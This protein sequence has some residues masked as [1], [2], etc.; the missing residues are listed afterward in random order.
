VI[1]LELVAVL[2]IGCGA[3]GFARTVHPP[4]VRLA[5]RVRPYN[6]VGRAGLGLAPDVAVRP[7]R[8]G[9]VESFVRPLFGGWVRGIGRRIESRSD[10]ELVK[11]LHQAGR[12]DLTVEEFRAR[13]VLRGAGGAAAF[14]GLGVVGLRSPVLAVA[15]AIAGF[16]WGSS[17][18][19]AGVDRAVVDRKARVRLELSTVSQLLALHVRTGAGLMHAVQRFSERG[20]GV[21]AEELRAVVASV[22]AGSRESD[23][24]RR[25]AELTSAPE[26]ARMHLLFANGVERGADLAASLLVIA[27]DLREAR[28]DD[29]KR[30]AVK[31]RAAM[32]LPTIGILAPVMLL[33][34]AAPLP[35]IIF[36]NR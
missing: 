33:F 2:G 28:R 10:D 8:G 13:Q 34:I 27:D 32:L 16:V 23:A 30:R 36:G 11:V 31:A 25:A 9:A 29:V 24:F 26:A 22:R 15:L 6:H 35:S 1:A 21:L 5:G 19:R 4:T 3:A 18:V 14:G 12:S 7:D 17:R 20:R